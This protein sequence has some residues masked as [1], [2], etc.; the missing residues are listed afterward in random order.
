MTGKGDFLSPRLAAE[1]RRLEQ[2]STMFGSLWT[3]DQERLVIE[4]NNPGPSNMGRSS[5]PSQTPPE[6]PPASTP[7]FGTRTRPAA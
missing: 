4:S 2:P 3:S 7:K 5:S 1:K 6:K